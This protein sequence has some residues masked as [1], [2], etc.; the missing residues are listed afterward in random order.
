MHTNELVFTKS[1]LTCLKAERT[2][3]DFEIDPMISLRRKHCVVAKQ[4]NKTALRKKY[5]RLSFIFCT[6]THKR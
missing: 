6:Y 3:K 4:E 2:K 5:I 1:F